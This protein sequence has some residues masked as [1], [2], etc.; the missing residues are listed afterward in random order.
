M[1]MTNVDIEVAVTID[2]LPLRLDPLKSERHAL[3]ML[4]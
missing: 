3:P 1:G 2:A 4:L